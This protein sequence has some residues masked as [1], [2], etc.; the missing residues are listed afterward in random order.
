MESNALVH[1]VSGASAMACCM[2]AEPVCTLRPHILVH[3][4]QVEGASY[5]KYGG[6]DGVQEARREQL[7]TQA[8]ARMKRKATETKQVGRTVQAAAMHEC[9][10]RHD[11]ALKPVSL[12]SVEDTNVRT[13]R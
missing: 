12:L 6:F 4:L 9:M 1:A 3:A 5:A 2:R 11:R 13:N 10:V 7:E 8:A